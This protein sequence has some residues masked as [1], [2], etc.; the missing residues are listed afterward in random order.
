[1]T[2]SSSLA[3]EDWPSEPERR[4]ARYQTRL[5][6][7]YG[8]DIDSRVIDTDAAGRIHFLTAGN[9]EDEP[10]V[11]LHGATGQ[12]A[13]WLPLMPALTDRYRVYAP[14]MPGKGWGCRPS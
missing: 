12:A 11:L 3:D 5:A 13:Y 10:V 6:D 9:P 8:L 7:Q 4:Y 14:D 2:I 1:M